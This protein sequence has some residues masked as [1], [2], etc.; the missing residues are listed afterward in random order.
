MTYHGHINKGRIEL[1]ENVGLPDGSA[2]RVEVSPIAEPQGIAPENGE[3]AE[4]GSTIEDEL[5]S[6]W[7][8]VPESEWAR[9]PHDLTDQLDHYVYGTPKK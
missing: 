7:A 3:T 2:V 5:K 6:L 8:D 9:L 4:N 1:E